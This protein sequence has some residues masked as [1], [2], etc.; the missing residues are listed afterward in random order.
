MTGPGDSGLKVGIAAREITP[1][2]GFH[3]SGFIA[4]TS[5]SLGAYDPLQLSVLAASDEHTTALIMVFDLIGLT[6]RWIAATRKRVTD[7]TGVPALNQMYACTHTHGDPETGVLL[8]SSGVNA[9]YMHSLVG[10]AKSAAQEALNNRI[11]AEL[12]LGAGTSYAGANRRSAEINPNGPHDG[13]IDDIDPT[14]I[15]AQLRRFDGR[16][17]VTV[18]NY[19]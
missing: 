7:A 6:P 10:Q 8:S 11:P 3:L 15:V 1:P 17:L 14:I 5:A 13:G 16:P 18:V 19:G 2:P 12:R 4:R 9:D